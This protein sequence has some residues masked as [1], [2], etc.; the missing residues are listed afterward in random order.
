MR[1]SFTGSV[2]K[3][4]MIASIFFTAPRLELA[5]QMA[6]TPIQMIEPDRVHSIT[7]R[8]ESRV[9]ALIGLRLIIILGLQH[10]EEQ[11]LYGNIGGCFL[12]HFLFGRPDSIVSPSNRARSYLDLAIAARPLALVLIASTRGRMGYREEVATVFDETTAV[13]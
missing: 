4:L 7:P 6:S 13:R 8:S 2:L 1:A 9:P 11:R 12:E 10:H 5:Y 3:G